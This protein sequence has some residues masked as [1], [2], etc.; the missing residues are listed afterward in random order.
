MQEFFERIRK[1]GFPIH[2]PGHAPEYF[3]HQGQ[4]LFGYVDLQ[5]GPDA[6]LEMDQDVLPFAVIL[7]RAE[8][9]HFAPGV[10]FA[11]R[12]GQALGVQ[13]EFHHARFLAGPSKHQHL[14]DEHESHEQEI[15]LPDAQREQ[16]HRDYYGKP[17]PGRA[18]LAIFEFRR[19][20]LDL[21]RHALILSVPAGIAYALATVSA[22][23]RRTPPRFR[24]SAASR[25]VA[26]EVVTSSKRITVALGGVSRRRKHPLRV[27]SKTFETGSPDPFPNMS[28][29]SSAW[30]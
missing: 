29:I 25:S 2:L 4:A 12:H 6:G 20:P 28:A 11:R 26:P 23:T 22:I 8:F 5:G 21:F 1:G 15:L 7:F 10:E 14:R 27:R 30:L 3:A 17:E 24:A 19:L 13:F 18:F 9:F 16:E